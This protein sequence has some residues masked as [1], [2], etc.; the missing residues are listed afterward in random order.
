MSHSS[1]LL[2]TAL[3]HIGQQYPESVEFTAAPNFRRLH[4]RRF[5]VFEAF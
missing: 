5:E 4:R 1:D 2:S 3:S